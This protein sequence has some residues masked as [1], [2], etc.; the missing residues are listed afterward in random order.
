MP[1]KRP[2]AAS[3]ELQ[4]GTAVIASIASGRD[5]AGE[6][7]DLVS[8]QLG[9]SAPTPEVEVGCGAVTPGAPEV[10]VCQ[11]EARALQQRLQR[12]ANPNPTR[13]TATQGHVCTLCRGEWGLSHDAV[14]T[15]AL[16]RWSNHTYDKSGDITGPRSDLCYV[17]ARGK[18]LLEADVAPLVVPRNNQ[19]IRDIGRWYILFT[20]KREKFISLHMQHTMVKHV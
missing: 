14:H 11:F 9:E 6:S 5:A 2:A 1:F 16:I 10:E 18:S 19:R 12:H 15:T 8:H 4:C 20:E 17:C 3:L 13:P 7:L